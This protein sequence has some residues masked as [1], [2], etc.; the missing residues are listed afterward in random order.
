MSVR[1]THALVIVI[2]VLGIFLGANGRYHNPIIFSTQLTMVVAQV[3]LIIHAM[4]QDKN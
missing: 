1:Q 4:K 3:I 2:G